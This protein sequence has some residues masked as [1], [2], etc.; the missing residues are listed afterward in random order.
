MLVLSYL[1][2]LFMYSS[3]SLHFLIHLHYS[4]LHIVCTPFHSHMLHLRLFM[5]LLVY[6][7]WLYLHNSMSY[8]YYYI[9]YFMHSMLLL[10]Y[11]MSIHLVLHLLLYLVLLH[12]LY[13]Y[14]YLH[15]L[16]FMLHHMLLPSLSLLH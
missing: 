3:L 5:T 16:H 14:N 10:R 12:L 8:S 15:Y 4:I 11:F 9:H 7:C 1:S 2:G 6:M 13:M